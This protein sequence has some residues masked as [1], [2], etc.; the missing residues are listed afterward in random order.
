MFRGRDLRDWFRRQPSQVAELALARLSNSKCALADAQFVIAR[1]HSFKSW[2]RFAK[3]IEALT[4]ASSPISQFESAADA[5]VNGDLA[6]LERLLR[7]D[8]GLSRAYSTREHQ[9]TLLHYVAANG[10]EDFRQQT[11]K[12]AVAVAEML[13][14]AGAEV[15]A[16][17]W[18]APY[19]R[20]TALGLVATSI[21]PWLA[22]VQNALLDTLLDHGASVDGLPGGANPLITAGSWRSS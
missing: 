15:D 7:E 9:A 19:Q 10:V 14:Y 13:L 4:S 5:V 2:S 20:S 18:R 17:N 22:G 1:V 8:P 3:H 11:T 16:V 6:T 21:H 12:N